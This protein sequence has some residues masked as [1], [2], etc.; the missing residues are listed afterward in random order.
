MNELSNERI[1]EI[2]NN[3]IEIDF[4]NLTDHFKGVNTAPINL[5]NFRGTLPISKSEGDQK[6]FKLSL[7]EITIGNQKYK[8][9]DQ[10]D[11]IKNFK[12]LYNSWQKVI[13]FFNDYAKIRSEA[14]FKTKHGTGLEI[15]SPKQMLQRLR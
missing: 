4:N 6:K 13:N 5:I 2:Y 11:A 12:N 7:S 9:Q 14:M 3:S 10:L 1:G 8:S 15:L